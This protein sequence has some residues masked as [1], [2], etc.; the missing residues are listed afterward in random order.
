MTGMQLPEHLI[1]AGIVD[2]AA[3]KTISVLVVD[4]HALIRS[5][6]VT[7]LNATDDIRVVAEAAN[8]RTP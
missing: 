8:G 6:L 5:A 4:D 3:L 7:V 1:S 2:M